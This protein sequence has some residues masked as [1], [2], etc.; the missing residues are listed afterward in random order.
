MNDKIEEA[1]K[2]G[3]LI[4]FSKIMAETSLEDR[5]EIYEKARYL[6]LSMAIRQLRRQLRLTQKDLAAKMKVKREVIARAES[7]QHNITLET[8]YRIA[9]A[10][11]KNITIDFQ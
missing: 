3:K 2:S 4:P 7:G 11:N 10:T 6:R 9:E 8:L 1:I 5:A